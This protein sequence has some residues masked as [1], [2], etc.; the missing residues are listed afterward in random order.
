MV[1]ENIVRNMEHVKDLNYIEVDKPS[2][3]THIKGSDIADYTADP[4][5]GKLYVLKIDGNFHGYYKYPFEIVYK[6]VEKL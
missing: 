4:E 5:S 2:G 1:N 6:N 3:K